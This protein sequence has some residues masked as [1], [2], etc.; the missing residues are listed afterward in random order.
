MTAS[1]IKWSNTRNKL[2][3]QFQCITVTSETTKA[4]TNC[5]WKDQKVKIEFDQ[6][7]QLYTENEKYEVT[8]GCSTLQDWM[9][10]IR[11]EAN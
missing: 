8:V 7:Q 10:T 2:E 4:I 9:W 3:Q 1:S 11:N 5:H 6:E